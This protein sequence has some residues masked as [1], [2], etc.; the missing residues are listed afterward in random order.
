MKRIIALLCV[1]LFALS[2]GACGS[3]DPETNYNKALEYL[4]KGDYE[5]A[6]RLLYE[7][8]DYKDAKEY[9]GKFRIYYTKRSFKAP[10]GKGTLHFAYDDFGNMICSDSISYEKDGIK[11]NKNAIICEFEY[12][13]NGRITK[14]INGE[15]NYTVYIYDS[16]GKLSKREEWR[17]ERA[18]KTKEPVL[19]KTEYIV[20]PDEYEYD[21]NGRMVKETVYDDEGNVSSVT[22]LT[23]DS[24]GRMVENIYKDESGE[25]QSI[26]K[27]E[28]D[29]SGNLLKI[30]DGTLVETCV[31]DSENV[32]TEIVGVDTETGAVNYKRI[33]DSDGNMVKYISYDSNGSVSRTTEYVYD[34]MGK[35]TKSVDYDSAGEMEWEQVCKYDKNGNLI[36]NSNTRHGKDKTSTVTYSYSDF[37]YFYYPDG[38]PE[39]MG[40]DPYDHEN[41]P[42]YNLGQKHY[43]SLYEIVLDKY[44]K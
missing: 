41:I 38:I 25:I 44:N 18:D 8:G 9:L 13:E 1:V 10:L 36:E 16:E 34:S 40:D 37:V 35:M 27:F 11:V 3:N 24:N 29:E 30:I 31:Y 43:H 7:L 19:V 2:L 22:E 5:K 4:E 21:D 39:V 23:Y 33:Y 28:Y 14:R 17:P 12:D 32:L 42:H 26:F 20:R 6:H 15:S